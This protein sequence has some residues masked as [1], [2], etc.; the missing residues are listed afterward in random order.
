MAVEA[1]EAA[2]AVVLGRAPQRADAGGEQRRGDGLAGEAPERASPRSRS[3]PARPPAARRQI[4]AGSCFT[5]D[6]LTQGREHQV[7][8]LP[9]LSPLGVGPRNSDSVLVD[10]DLL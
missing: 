10:D 2:R 8:V 6:T 3:S 1:E 4:P 7:S 5:R 9:Y